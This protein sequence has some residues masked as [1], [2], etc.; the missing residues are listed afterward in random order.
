MQCPSSCSSLSGPLSPPLR[1][2]RDALQLHAIRDGNLL[3]QIDKHLDGPP[4]TRAQSVWQQG[5]HRILAAAG[6]HAARRCCGRRRWSAQCRSRA[7]GGGTTRHYAEAKLRCAG[8]TMATRYL[9]WCAS[10]ELTETWFKHFC[11]STRCLSKRGVSA[12]FC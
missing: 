8:G 2:P 9:T 11:D 5:L 4:E 3:A 1:V 10:G 12:T 6:A 7:G